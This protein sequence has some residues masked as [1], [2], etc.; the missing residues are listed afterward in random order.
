MA[1]D[2][3]TR[4]PQSTTQEESS[5]FFPRFVYG[6]WQALKG[7]IC[8]G[9]AP[10]ADYI[11]RAVQWL[12]SVQNADGGWGET[13]DSYKDVTL[14]AKGKSTASQTAWAVMGL[15]TAGEID[16]PEVDR[17]MEF[18]LSTQKEDGTWDEPEY[19]GTGFPDVFYLRYGLYRVTFP[20]FALGYYRNVRDGT[21]FRGVGDKVITAP[22]DRSRA[23]SLEVR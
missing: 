22:R 6:T 20:L 10:E 21:V 9:E 3:Y 5:P 19:T 18:L 13:C 14:K 7:L 12:K 1:L 17:G 16:S 11:Q 8:V 23:R 2:R 15:V 4:S